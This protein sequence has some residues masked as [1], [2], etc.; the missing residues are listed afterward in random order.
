MD[1]EQKLK[2]Y[3]NEGYNVILTGK[4]G[5]G[6]TAIIT[7]VF[8]SVFGEHNVRWKYFSASTLD[9]WVDFIGIPKNYTRQDGKEVFTIIP[10][11]HFTG[12]EE[13][14]AIFFDEINRTD[15]KTL[16]AIMELIQFKSINGRKFPHLKCVW[17]AENPSDD[18]NF[19]YSVKPLD[20]AQKDRFQ[21]QLIIPEHLNK[22]YFTAKYGAEVFKLASSWWKNNTDKISPRKLD[23]ILEGYFKGFDIRDFT[24]HKSVEELSHAL[25]SNIEYSKMK[26]VAETSSKEDI[27][28]HFTLDRIRKYEKIIRAD[29]SNYLLG[30]I[31]EQLDEE[32]KAYIQKEF[33][34]YGKTSNK[35]RQSHMLTEQVEFID[36]MAARQSSLFI[37]T[38]TIEIL[39]YILK[40]TS[41][42]K[43]D[44]SVNIN[45]TR[46]V[47]DGFPFKFTSS[48]STNQ[49]RSIVSVSGPDV[50]KV[51]HWFV[52]SMF[53]ISHSNIKNYDKLHLYNILNKLAGNKDF[54]HYIK[55]NKIFF[56]NW[57]KNFPKDTYETYKKRA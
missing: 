40:F 3:A 20:P 28:T 32:V 5:I 37:D 21:I 45:Y 44:L 38:N 48:L 9:P 23:S 31:Y 35:T 12:D 50:D 51:K 55:L 42:F 15:E 11:E 22:K 18:T 7:E 10:P 1:L 33:G 17:A 29:N 6:K 16:N 27:E 13:I 36:H 54:V 39:N 14:N 8:G 4:H 41:V 43:D 2:L 46:A 24:V 30:K 53:M 26:T 47:V 57:K 49:I 25:D 34:Y 19:E 56:N 52:T